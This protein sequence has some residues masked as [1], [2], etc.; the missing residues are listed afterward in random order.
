VK[1]ATNLLGQRVAVASSNWHGEITPRGTGT[2]RAVVVHKGVFRLLVELHAIDGPDNW[3][4]PGT[5]IGDLSTVALDYGDPTVGSTLVRVVEPV[6]APPVIETLKSHGGDGAVFT[7]CAA[8]SA[9]P[10]S[11]TYCRSCVANRDT[12]FRLHREL[13]A[14]EIRIAAFINATGRQP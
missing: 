4:I 1:V 7:E 2:V 12:I 11:P 14:A 5:A 6:V 3:W 10:G 13:R 9:K 8:C